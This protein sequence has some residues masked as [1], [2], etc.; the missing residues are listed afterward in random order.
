M[1]HSFEKYEVLSLDTKKVIVAISDEV[2]ATKGFIHGA[3]F[4]SSWVTTFKSIRTEY[5]Q[6]NNPDI[7]KF[8]SWLEM[9]HSIWSHFS[10]CT[11][12]KVNGHYIDAFDEWVT[13]LFNMWKVTVTCNHVSS[14]DKWMMFQIEYLKINN[15]LH[16]FVSIVAFHDR[17]VKTLRSHKRRHLHALFLFIKVQY[18]CVRELGVECNSRSFLSW[19]MRQ[20]KIYDDHLKANAFRSIVLHSNALHDKMKTMSFEEFISI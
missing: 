18:I 7:N 1:P 9:I 12:W 10:Q 4:V 17:M 13:M 6:R 11:K 20:L 3:V 15:S 16:N 2:L 14:F 5:M 8:N 19:Q